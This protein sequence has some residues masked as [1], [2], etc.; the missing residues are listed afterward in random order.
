MVKRRSERDEPHRRPAPPQE[1]RLA[2]RLAKG[3]VVTVF[4]GYALINMIRLVGEGARMEGVL[5]GVGSL[6]IVL[7]VLMQLLHFK[8]NSP[9][10]MP[11]WRLVM[12]V[13]QAALIYLP[14]LWLGPGWLGMPSFLASNALLVL[15]AWPAWT[16][17]SLVVTG[18][19]V[20]EAVYDTGLLSL[21]YAAASSVITALVVYGLTRMSELVT[22]VYQSRIALAQMAVEKERGRFARDLH[23]L[24][25]YSLSAIT[26]KTE[27]ARRLNGTGS[28]R[29]NEELEDVLQISRQ[30]LADVRVVSRGYRQMSLDDELKSARTILAATEIRSE[31]R[32]DPCD[33]GELSERTSTVLATVLR[34]GITNMLRHSDPSYCSITLRYESGLVRMSM[35]N[36]GV[37]PAPAQDAAGPSGQKGNRDESREGSGI[38][39]LTTRV[40]AVGGR[41]VAGVAPDGWFH[42]DVEVR[43][44]PPEDAEG[45]QELPR[46]ETGWGAR[47]RKWTGLLSA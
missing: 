36:D 12:L 46:P 20:L 35:R 24:L 10:R 29:A 7:L 28:E 2:P 23:D 16:I 33:F 39:N 38:R 17:F 27:L 18:N 6:L 21:G 3:V 25:G 8:R 37:R 14:L 42:L 26:L 41:L 1:I 13:A 22:E 45:P 15:S 31:V 44:Q 30:A 43:A 47:A 9:W 5:I 19:V 34:E 11:R 32:A 40:E 4:C